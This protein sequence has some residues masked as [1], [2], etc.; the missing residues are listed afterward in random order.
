MFTVRNVN[1]KKMRRIAR[2]DDN[3][4]EIVVALRQVG[5][6]VQP[7]HTLGKGV[8]DLLIGF[9]GQN[10]LLEVKDGSKPPSQQKL[11][12]DEKEW[13]KMWRGNVATVSTVEEAMAGIGAVTR[14][15]RMEHGKGYRLAA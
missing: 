10:F 2:T 9:R 11:T 12:P 7:I 4:K 3:Q 15:V 13:H 14:P 1:K 6:S 8:P 5:A